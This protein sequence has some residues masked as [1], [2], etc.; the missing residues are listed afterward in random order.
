MGSRYHPPQ[1]Q[2][3]KNGKIRY[4]T[5][6]F[7][8]INVHKYIGNP[9]NIVYRSGWELV[10]M[11]FLDASTD[12]VRWSSEKFII[13]YQDK[14]GK[15]HRYESDFYFEKV[16][17]QDPNILDKFVV[18]LKPRKEFMPDFVNPDG[19]IKSPEMYLKKVTAKSLESYEYQLK[20]YQ[21]NLYKWTK[22][23]YWCEKNGMQFVIIDEVYLA[24]K[25]IN[26]KQKIK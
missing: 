2:Y 26:L 25:G 14:E 3:K 8:P 11:R 17:S 12:V 13:P 1:A 9:T 7:N 16:N 22:A 20:T 23:K 10:F 24:S 19:S 5:N 4:H 18:E 15:F 6:F 21:K